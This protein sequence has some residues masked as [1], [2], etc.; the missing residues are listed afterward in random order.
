MEHGLKYIAFY[1]QNIKQFEWSC[2][3]FP[4]VRDKSPGGARICETGLLAKRDFKINHSHAY[5]KYAIL[6][7]KAVRM[8]LSD[9]NSLPNAPDTPRQW[10]I[11][12]ITRNMTANV[13]VIFS[14]TVCLLIIQLLWIGLCVF[15]PRWLYIQ[16]IQPQWH[17]KR[18]VG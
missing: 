15:T 11:I 16:F 7:T 18:C 12:S 17:E 5:V 10:S 9:I 4:L 13:S 6:F 14:S 3:N 1:V 2:H 8:V